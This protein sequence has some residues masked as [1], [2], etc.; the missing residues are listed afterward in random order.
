ML[1]LP[2]LRVKR[3]YGVGMAR[4]PVGSTDMDLTTPIPQ[5]HRASPRYR[6]FLGA[7]LPQ[8][9][10]IARLAQMPATVDARHN[11]DSRAAGVHGYDLRLNR[12]L[13]VTD[14]VHC[15]HASLACT[16]AAANCSI[17]PGAGWHLHP[18]HGL[19]V[20]SP[21]AWRGTL[22][23]FASRGLGSK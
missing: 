20:R 18:E 1:V 11:I 17:V 13:P 19:V 15:W 2:G 16:P 21:D 7:H 14:Q 9:A 4:R 22:A 12:Q 3:F 10:P 6:L 8:R 5:K 23:V